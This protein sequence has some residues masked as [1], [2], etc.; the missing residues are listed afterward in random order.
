METLTKSILEQR[1]KEKA[2]ERFKKE[3][4]TAIHDIL[5]RFPFLKQLKYSIG[6][7]KGMIFP[8]NAYCVTDLLHQQEGDKK[9]TNFLELQ[10]EMVKRYEKEELD[11]ILNSLDGV[12]FLF[13]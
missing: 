6:A 9:Q 13:Q 10:E 5:E 8:N 2:E 7:E 11:K 4:W 1:I 12:K 3:Y